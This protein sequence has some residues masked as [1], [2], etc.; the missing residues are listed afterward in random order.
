MRQIPTKANN[1]WTLMT[2]YRT[3][4][5]GWLSASHYFKYLNLDTVRH[6]SDP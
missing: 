1:V 6:L 5:M 3:G 4:S 2:Y